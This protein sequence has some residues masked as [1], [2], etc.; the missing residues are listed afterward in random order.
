MEASGGF[1]NDFKDENLFFNKNRE[2]KTI[3]REPDQLDN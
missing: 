1:L 3:S 2:E